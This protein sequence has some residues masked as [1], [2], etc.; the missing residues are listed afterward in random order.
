[1]LTPDQWRALKL[2][3]NFGVVL[4]SA[5]FVSRMAVDLWPLLSEALGR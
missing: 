4:V 2:I 3:V 5:I 1:M